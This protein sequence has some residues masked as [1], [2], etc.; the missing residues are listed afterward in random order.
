MYSSYC[1]YLR[2][3]GKVIAL[4]SWINLGLPIAVG[5][6]VS[7]TPEEMIG[8]KN[9]RTLETYIL[10]R[11]SF[12][13]HKINEISG[14]SE[15][16]HLKEDIRSFAEVEL[17]DILNGCSDDSLAILDS[18]IGSTISYQQDL[19]DSN[20]LNDLQ[21]NLKGFPEL[22]DLVVEITTKV[23]EE[24][25]HILLF[26]S[27]YRE[28]AALSLLNK[29][30]FLVKDELKRR[31]LPDYLYQRLTEST[32]QELNIEHL[33]PVSNLIE[34]F[35]NLSVSDFLQD[36]FKGA[37]LLY[38]LLWGIHENETLTNELFKHI[39]TDIDGGYYFESPL[40]EE[41]VYVPNEFVSFKGIS[42]FHPSKNKLIRAIGMYILNQMPETGLKAYQLYDDP[43]EGDYL[44]GHNVLVYNAFGPK[45]RV[46]GQEIVASDAL[47]LTDE[48]DVI[49]D[50]YQIND[51]EESIEEAPEAFKKKVKISGNFVLSVSGAKHAR[52]IYYNKSEGQWYFFNN[53][54]QV[55]NEG[56]PLKDRPAPLIKI[57][58][59]TVRN[60]IGKVSSDSDLSFPYVRIFGL[61][62]VVTLSEG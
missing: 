5:M 19:S 11:L 7:P 13:A 40:T 34:G 32:V 41:V 61:F 58:N 4:V 10:K 14:G 35:K 26:S 27:K 33:V 6:D 12:Y 54:V 18:F 62:D 1:V 46:E 44:F 8:C 57:M 20:V 49:V 24:G 36:Q 3:I 42:N 16:I 60:L 45:I 23:N 56:L 22:Y 17:R 9:I 30:I 15:L 53:E 47:W 43:E 50:T 38:S 59:P 2:S 25:E 39:M 31:E 51:E 28:K 55:D 48:G 37:C 21:E 52:V 29:V